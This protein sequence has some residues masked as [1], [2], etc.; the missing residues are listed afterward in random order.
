MEKHNVTHIRDGRKIVRYEYRGVWVLRIDG[1]LVHHKNS[2]HD[3]TT[4]NVES[5]Q[6]KEA[7]AQIDQWLD[8]N[9]RTLGGKLVVPYVQDGQLM[10]TIANPDWRHPHARLVSEIDEENNDY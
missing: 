6:L 4:V 10:N 9:G 7:C 2:Y 3:K 1:V 5:R 8:T